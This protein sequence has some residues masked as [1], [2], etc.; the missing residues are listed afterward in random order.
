VEGVTEPA[1]TYVVSLLE[2]S[3][4]VKPKWLMFIAAAAHVVAQR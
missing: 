3:V 4:L 1:M 2:Q